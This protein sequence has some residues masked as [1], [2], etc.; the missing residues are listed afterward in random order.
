MFVG[1]THYETCEVK[2][3]STTNYEHIVYADIPVD[4]QPAKTR[5]ISNSV[6]TQNG[7]TLQGVIVVDNMLVEFYGSELAWRKL[8]A[9]G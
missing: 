6:E 2:G 8:I 9:M 5:K 4:I 3:G 1:K 7:L